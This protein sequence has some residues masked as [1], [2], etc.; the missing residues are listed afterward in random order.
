[1]QQCLRCRIVCSGAL[2]NVWSS[3]RPM[4][5]D[6][7]SHNIAACCWG[8]FG[9]QCCVLLHGTKSLTGF[10]LY[11]TSANIVVVPCK[12]TQNVGPNN[13]VLLANNVA[14]LCMGLKIQK[15]IFGREKTLTSNKKPLLSTMAQG[16]LK[17]FLYYINASPLTI[18]HR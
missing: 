1:M 11:A 6:A 9:Q 8:F 16:N 17:C 10:K 5:T 14:S 12:R 18:Q 13:V 3:Q 4:Q 7:T 2:E 15:L